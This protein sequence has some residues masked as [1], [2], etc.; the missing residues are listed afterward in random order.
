MSQNPKQ[1]ESSPSGMIIGAIVILSLIAWQRYKR[2]MIFF[3]F[4]HRLELCLVISAL[5]TGAMLWTLGKF[6]KWLEPKRLEAF[7]FGKKT[8]ES[9]VL[10]GKSSEDQSVYFSLDH[11]LLH[12]HV[13][14]GTGSGKTESTITQMAVDDIKNGRG[15]IIIDGKSDRALLN[16]L[17]AYADRFGRNEDFKI[18]SLADTSISQTFNPF[19]GGSVI[20]TTERI[21]SALNFEN[22]YYKSIQ[23]DALMHALLILE[24]AKVLPTPKK[25][26]EILRSEGQMNFLAA[27]GRDQSLI[28]WSQQFQ[29][30]SS[31]ERESRTSGLIT[32]LQSFN[33]GEMGPIFNADFSD[34]VI[35]EAMAKNEIIYCQLP[36][37]K[38]PSLGKATGKL[39]LQSLQSAISSRHLGKTESKNFFSIYLDDFTEYLTPSFVTL[40]NKSRSANV[41][42]VFAHQALGDLDILG[43]GLKNSVLTNSNLKI[44]M[45]TNEPES[46]EYFASVVGTVNA[47]KT[48]ERQ[49]A[50]TFGSHRTG[51]G[52][53]RE[54]EEFKYH[55]NLFKQKLGVGEAVVILPHLQGAL[56]LKMKFNRLIDL[57]VPKIPKIKK[58]EQTGL[59]AL[60][61]LA[62]TDKKTVEASKAQ[63]LHVADGSLMASVVA[64]AERADANNGCAGEDQSTKMEGG[65]A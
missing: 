41:G 3:Y 20:E 61:A 12:T 5:V 37:M 53:V 57:G 21:F 29:K 50:G 7:V 63:A 31:S 45:R 8:G 14:G 64:A 55:P 32:Q 16:K 25:V 19:S 1:L 28:E 23:Y 4:R 43:E 27:L 47:K 46:S 54:A 65:A 26:I 44:F 17:F 48:T 51:D 9:S 62:E 24:A 49:V 34:I 15:L 56:P 22:E 40:L 39:I 36:A 38:I 60:A 10:M 58:L 33:I 35:E 18:L 52:S 30:L 13:V 6:N 11:R 59:P 42:V 2:D